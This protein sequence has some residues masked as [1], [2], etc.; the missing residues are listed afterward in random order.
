MKLVLQMLVLKAYER[1]LR[2]IKRAK[3]FEAV[4][5]AI[6]NALCLICVYSRS[7]KKL[8]ESIEER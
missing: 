6:F 7:N 5:A 4:F 2:D 8:R 3:I 1:C